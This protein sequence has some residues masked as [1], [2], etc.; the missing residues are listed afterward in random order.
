MSPSASTTVKP[1]E[2]KEN[3]IHFSYRFTYKPSSFCKQQIHPLLAK[4]QNAGLLKLQQ[5]SRG[6]TCRRNQCY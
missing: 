3:K 4:R 6:G 1:K 2:T 5:N